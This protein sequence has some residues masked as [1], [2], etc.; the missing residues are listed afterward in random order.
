MRSLIYSYLLRFEYLVY[1]P[2][3]LLAIW[4]PKCMLKN[5]GLLLCAVSAS[6]V[7]QCLVC[8]LHLYLLLRRVFCLL[9]HR[10]FLWRRL[11]KQQPTCDARTSYTCYEHYV[12]VV[13]V[14]LSCRWRATIKVLMWHV[15]ETPSITLLWFWSRQMSLGGWIPECNYANCCVMHLDCMSQ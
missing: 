5:K 3:P 8:V 11:R 13:H 10:Q 9:F 14:Y 12:F 6:C 2:F 7:P 4:L 15:A 1:S